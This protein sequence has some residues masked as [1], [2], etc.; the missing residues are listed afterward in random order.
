LY[1][2]AFVV[3]MILILYFYSKKNIFNKKIQRNFFFKHF[4]HPSPP[5]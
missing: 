2:V 1:L 4:V 5:L 3:N